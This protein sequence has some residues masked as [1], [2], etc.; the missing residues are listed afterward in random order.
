MGFFPYRPTI[1]SNTELFPADCAPTTAI[2]GNVNVNFAF[3]DVNICW[4]WLIIGINNSIS[5]K[6]EHE[7]SSDNEIF[8]IYLDFLLEYSPWLVLENRKCMAYAVTHLTKNKWRYFFFFCLRY[9]ESNLPTEST[10]LYTYRTRTN[11]WSYYSWLSQR[12][13]IC[14]FV[15]LGDDYQ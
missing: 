13:F 10:H 15:F 2:C 7:I 4:S 8:N 6:I 3:T 1:F 14:L 11:E 9:D 5:M 12:L